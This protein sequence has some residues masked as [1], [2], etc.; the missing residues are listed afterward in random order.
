MILR[1]FLFVCLL[2]IAVIAPTGF[3]IICAFLYAFRFTAYELIAVCVFIDGMYGTGYQLWVPYY[4]IIT[5]GVLL[6]IE[7]VKPHI[8]LYNEGK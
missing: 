3:F 7:W 2:V 6:C 8:S 1:P 5:C 4:T